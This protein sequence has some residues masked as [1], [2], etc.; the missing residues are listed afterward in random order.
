MA[1]IFSPK[2]QADRALAENFQRST[3]NPM[4]KVSRGILILSLS[5]SLSLS[6]FHIY[7]GNRTKL[8]LCP[9][10]RERDPDKTGGAQWM[11]G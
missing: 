11:Y 9:R 8:F 1:K 3:R 4:A 2:V 7:C 6:L 5:L 10:G